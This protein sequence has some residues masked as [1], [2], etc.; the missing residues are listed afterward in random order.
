MNFKEKLLNYF[1]LNEDDYLAFIKDVKNLKIEDYH[2]FKGIIEAKKIILETIKDNKKIMVYGDYD[3]DGIMAT[4]ILINCFKKLGIDVGYYIPSRVIDGYGIT[5]DR[6]KQIKEKGYSLLITVDNGVKQFEALNY[7]FENKVKV[8]L[9]DHHTYDNIP[10]CE[11]FLHPYNKIIPEDNCGAYVAFMLATCLLD[12]IDYYLLS[13]AALATISDMMPMNNLNNRNLVKIALD[14]LKKDIHHPFYFLTNKKIDEEVLAFEIAPKINSYGR[15]I[16][17]TA[18]NRIIKLFTDSIDKYKIVDEIEMLNKERKNIL[19]EAFEKTTIFEDKSIIAINENLKDGLIGL[20]AARLL[21]IYQ[22]PVV[23]F[24]LHDGILKGSARSLENCP[25]T[26]FFSQ[27]DDILLK[28]GGHVLAG[29]L[30]IDYKNFD[31]FKTRF[32]EFVA[33]HKYKLI[34]KRFIEITK[35]EINFENYL[36]LN[37]LSPFGFNFE[38][39]LFSLKINK[40]ELTYFKE[41]VKAN[42]NQY[43]SLIGFNLKNKIIDEEIFFLGKI[44][45]DSYKENALI[46]LVNEIK[47]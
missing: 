2:N 39:P 36:F 15:M 20:L 26:L 33:N 41:H 34:E 27:N 7:L 28:S 1:H 35:D 30:S 12:N 18:I 22:K 4:S 47:A 10:P 46:F 16:E 13:L 14:Y 32:N 3:C 38:E 45:I 6:A 29:G 19:N 9:T 44:K 37:S 11:V 25:L 5:L 8:I 42:L 21:N 40:Y 31:L 17:N 43:S 23:V 24:N